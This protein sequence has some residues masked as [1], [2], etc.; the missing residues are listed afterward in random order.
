MIRVLH[1]IASLGIGGT[2]AMVMNL[3]QKTDRSKV[4]FDFIIDHSD[5]PKHTYFAEEIKRLGGKIYIMPTFRGGNILEI[6]KAWDQ[7][8]QTHKEYRILHVHARSYACI[9]LAI[10]KK[11]GIKTIVHSHSTSNGRGFSALVKKVLQYPLRYQADYFFGCS[12]SAGEWLFGKKVAG[13]DRY[14][15]I[16]NAV[17]LDRYRFNPEM[18]KQYRKLIGA[19]EN[20]M[21]YVHVGRLHESKNHSFLLNV[22][23]EIQKKKDDSLLVL[24]GEGELRETIEEQIK[25]SQIDDKVVML[26]ARNDVPCILF[27]ADYFLFPSKWE[28]L[29]ISLIEAQATGLPCFISENVPMEAVICRDVKILSLEQG[30]SR[31]G[32]EI[33][34]GMQILPDRDRAYKEVVNAGYD[35]NEVALYLQ[36]LYLAV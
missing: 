32:E 9:Y 36:E 14:H 13:S 10:A 27:A 24:V 21:V 6:V 8:F 2:Q 18:R 3:Y 33:I 23:A 16:R 28:G 29:G 26:G 34:M 7:F 22:F 20:T 5:H 15:L 17:D 25:D 12:M 1:M 30:C 31:W 4:Q 19:E 35:I 11:Y